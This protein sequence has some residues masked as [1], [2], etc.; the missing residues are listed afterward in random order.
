MEIVKNL[1]PTARWTLKC[2]YPMNPQG[3]TVHNTAND[4]PAVNEISYMIRNDTSTSFHY[5]VDDI[6][7]VQGLEENRNGWHAG[8]G[9][10]FGNR[11]TIGIE[12]CYSK[13]GGDRFVK[14]EIN[15]AILIAGILKRYNW[16]I[17]KVGTHQ[18]RSGKYCPHRT[19]DMGWERFLNLIRSK[20]E[21]TWI[22]MD[23]PRKMRL[24]SGSLVNVPTGKVIKTY[25]FGS[26]FD[27]NQKTTWEGRLYLRTPYS[28]TNKI[29]NGF[30]FDG[31][32]EM[33][34]PIVIPVVEPPKPIPEP[35]PIPEPIPEPVIDTS[36]DNILLIEPE[37]TPP[38]SWLSVL[39]EAIVKIIK[40]IL[41]KE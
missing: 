41:G 9:N 32:E 10:G 30:L 19:L 2:P 12:I 15:A 34:E 16:G 7:A 38:K 5:A 18:M 33:P 29:S 24:I 3:I 31:L 13:S 14:S 8:D 4:A 36:E 26:T 28:S 40:L 21:P 17:D 39:L 37:V 20:L 25:A 1:V 27:F 6:R 35:E 11:S 23:V 22:P